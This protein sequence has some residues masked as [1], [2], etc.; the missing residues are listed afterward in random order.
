MKPNQNLPKNA[1]DTNAIK[2]SN[3]AQPSSQTAHRSLTRWNCNVCSL[4]NDGSTEICAVCEYRRGT[5]SYHAIQIQKPSVEVKN[6]QLSK[7]QTPS[8]GTTWNCLVCTLENQ[9]EA[10]T[11]IA[12]SNK[13]GTTPREAL[14]SLTIPSS[15]PRFQAPQLSPPKN[16]S[17]ISQ[18]KPNEPELKSVHSSINE[19]LAG[20]GNKS[21]LFRFFFKYSLFRIY[22]K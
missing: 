8:T 16:P 7:N 10:T 17:P 19:E 11:C 4:E 18:P 2:L 22:H 21:L 3:T 13:K 20:L 15:S 1:I 14:Q 6:P 5:K 12:C 9:S